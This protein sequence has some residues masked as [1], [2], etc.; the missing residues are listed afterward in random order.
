LCYVL[1]AEK[2]FWN[3]RLTAF[4]PARRTVYAVTFITDFVSKT[5]LVRDHRRSH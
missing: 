1:S 3:R 5:K 2:M 4:N